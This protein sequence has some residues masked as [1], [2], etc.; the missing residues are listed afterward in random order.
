MKIDLETLRGW[1]R[2]GHTF[3]YLLFWGHRQKRKGITDASCLSQ[4]F[5]A[6]F[7]VDGVRYA[8]AE[9]WMMAGKARLFGDTGMLAE[10]L[11]APGPREAKAFGR[12][13]RGFDEAKWSAARSELVIEGSVA[14]FSQNEPLK[15]FL[16]GTGR[17]I[18]VEASPRDRIWGIGMGASNPDATHP[19]KWR[20]TN[21]LGFALMETRARLGGSLGGPSR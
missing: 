9:H 13:V 16:L 8:T 5:P 20:G 18:L 17:K 10:I 15:T 14:K 1:A 12:R 19:L 6:T 4:W 21:L 7:V 11:A 3:D 2:D